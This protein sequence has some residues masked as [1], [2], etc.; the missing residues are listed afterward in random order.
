LQISRLFIDYAE[1]KTNK[2]TNKHYHSI[3]NPFF[4][5]F[6]FILFWRNKILSSFSYSNQVFEKFEEKNCDSEKKYGNWVGRVDPKNDE[7]SLN[8]VLIKAGFFGNLILEF[9]VSI[10]YLNE[11]SKFWNFQVKWGIKITMLSNIKRI[12]W[13]FTKTGIL[14]SIVVIW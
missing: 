5:F 12:R 6:Y 11:T 1:I 10:R 2:E 14:N 7:V 9:S 8:L 3:W 13:I 4:I